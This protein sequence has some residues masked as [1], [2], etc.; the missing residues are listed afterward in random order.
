M[1]QGKKEHGIKKPRGIPAW[2]LA[3]EQVRASIN[4]PEILK[5]LRRHIK[6]E[7][8]MLPTQVKAAEI[9]LR[10]CLPD[11]SQVDISGTLNKSVTVSVVSFADLTYDAEGNPIHGEAHQQGPE[12]HTIQ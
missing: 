3:A 8:K 6:G 2:L 7:V 12:V 5:H 4:A 9:L 1:A 10:K 11:L